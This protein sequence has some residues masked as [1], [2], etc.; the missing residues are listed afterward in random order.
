MSVKESAEIDLM[1][2]AGQIA[3]E[4]YDAVLP[5]IRAGLTEEQVEIL[6]KEEMAG[7]G[8][9]P[10]FAIVATGPNS[11]EPHHLTDAT[12]LQN[13]DVLILDFGCT[14]DGYY[15]DITRTVAVGT[16]SDRAREVYGV[17]Y[18]A[19]MAGRHAVHAGATGAEVDAAARKVIA[20]AGFGSFF[21]HRTGHGIGM[22]GHEFP[23]IVSSN[24][25][26]LQPGNCFSIEPGI[27]LPLE[28]GVRVE[29]IVTCT[30]EGHE[31]LNAEPPPSIPVCG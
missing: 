31:S 17:V 10:E 9:K 23:Y 25:V 27:Y 24:D 14:V 8:G 11:A 12:V 30:A 18:G 22:N 20:D 13:G 29:N 1:R 7:R 2:R 15:S 3:D 6:L 26:P 19:H 21:V 28:L 4:A 5:K 16:A